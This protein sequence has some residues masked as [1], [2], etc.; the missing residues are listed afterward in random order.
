MTAGFDMLSGEVSEYVFVAGSGLIT[1]AN[2]SK[3]S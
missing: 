3:D 2:I 1:G